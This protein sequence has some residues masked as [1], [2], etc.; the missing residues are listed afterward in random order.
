LPEVDG[1]DSV[2]QYHP[3]YSITNDMTCAI[4]ACNESA[5]LDDS[6][7]GIDRLVTPG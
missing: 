5:I 6:V 2:L 3:L 1:Q 7:S 4:L